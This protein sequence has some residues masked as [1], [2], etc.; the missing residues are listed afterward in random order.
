MET[1]K[2]RIKE[3]FYYPIMEGK[4]TFEIRNNDRDFKV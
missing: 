3:K 2:L 1:H 4:K